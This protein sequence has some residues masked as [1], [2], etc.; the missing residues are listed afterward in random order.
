[1]TYYLGFLWLMPLND[2]AFMVPLQTREKNRIFLQGLEKA[3]RNSFL[4]RFV[5]VLV[6]W[7]LMNQGNLF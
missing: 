7:I 6:R 2:D 4:L 5:L 1:M 3:G